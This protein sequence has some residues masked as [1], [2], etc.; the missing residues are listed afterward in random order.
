MTTNSALIARAV[1]L[2][3]LAGRRVATPAEAREL[4]GLPERKGPCYRIRPARVTG[5]R[6]PMLRVLETA[7]MHRVP[8]PEMDDFDVGDWFVAEVEGEIVGV[9]GHRIL[10]DGPGLPARPPCSPSSPTSASSGS[11][12][13]SRACGWT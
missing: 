5:D 9:A 3:D 11:G 12:G 8:S 7:N 13:R 2:A 4:L 6:E 10:R 1:A